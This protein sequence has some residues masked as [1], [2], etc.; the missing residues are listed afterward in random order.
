LILVERI[1][2]GEWKPGQLIPTEFEIA[3]E[4]HVSQGT[5]RKA[6]GELAN[7]NLVVRR[8]GMGT[9]VYEHSSNDI[10]SRFVNLYSNPGDKI[11]FESCSHRSVLAP[12]NRFER[13]M[14]RLEEGDQ[15]CR[16]DRVRAYKGEPI[17]SE[18]ISLPIKY[19]PGFVDLGEIPNTFYNIF[20]KRFGVLVTYTEERLSAVE[21][22]AR[23]SKDLKVS[24]GGPLLRIE[25]VAFDGEPVE[26]RVSLCNSE[27]LHFLAR[28]F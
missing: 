17:V 4:F 23:S 25:R 10:L 16:V 19:F 20:Q 26:H 1:R 21:S 13:K 2:S 14:L 5:A 11:V 9:F 3:T 8:Q 24:V 18:T 15:L 6:I 22:T 7:A 27:N 28:T 12:A